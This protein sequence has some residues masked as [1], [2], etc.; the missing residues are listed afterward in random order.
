MCEC[1]RATE[2]W[3]QK[4][5]LDLHP[6]VYGVYGKSRS[7]RLSNEGRLEF[8]STAC[9]SMPVRRTTTIGRY[10]R[11][12]HP[13][14]DPTSI[15]DFVKPDTSRRQNAEPSTRSVRR[16]SEPT[17]RWGLESLNLAID[18]GRFFRSVAQSNHH[19]EEAWPSQLHIRC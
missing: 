8:P 10:S 14:G 5:G 9:S 15:S 11:A 4:P 3:D 13:S 18:S 16:S 19:R 6:M 12:R 7:S 2:A 1:S 17:P